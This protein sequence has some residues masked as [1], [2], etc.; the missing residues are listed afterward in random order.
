M[1]FMILELQKEMRKLKNPAKAKVLAGF[2]KTGKGQYGEGDE[3]LGITVPQTRA[4]IKKFQQLSLKEIEKL[5]Q[6]EF[7]E[8]R[9]A[10]ILILVFQY[11]KGDE[12]NRQSIF[13]FYLRSNDK[14]NSWDLVDLSAPQIVG[15]FLTDKSKEI[16]FKLA[17]SKSL[18]ERRIAMVATFTDIKNGKSQTTFAIAEKLL[19]DKEDL[20][21]K[22]T[23][24]MLREVGKRCSQEEEE[25]FLKKHA[26]TMPRTMLRYALEHFPEE[27]RQLYLKYKNR[28]L[29]FRT[30]PPAYGGIRD[31][32]SLTN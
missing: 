6:S 1:N 27:K 31:P 17:E 13:E 9:L 18:W 24:W 15:E 26:A 19:K 3:F 10:A 2:F 29:S 4:A 25:I 28:N 16:L 12:K 5:L 20:L 22:A 11:A 30:C 7:H 8:E 21:H 14:I 32:E 23:G